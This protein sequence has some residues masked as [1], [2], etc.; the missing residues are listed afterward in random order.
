MINV[1]DRAT[2]RYRLEGG[3]TDPTKLSD[4]VR[5]QEGK[6]AGCYVRLIN[7]EG[8][9]AVY[10]LYANGRLRRYRRV[11]MFN[12]LGETKSSIES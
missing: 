5:I 7:D 3:T 6:E 8:V 10:K 12:Q 9:I 11:S 1:Y 2:R 4:T